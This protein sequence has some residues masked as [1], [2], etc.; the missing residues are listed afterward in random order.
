MQVDWVLAIHLCALE[1]SFN[2]PDDCWKDVWCVY[3]EEEQLWGF[4]AIY[5][6]F[7]FLFP[8]LCIHWLLSQ[9]YF[10]YVI[11]NRIARQNVF[12]ISFSTSSYSLTCFTS[13]KYLKQ[14]SQFSYP[15]LPTEIWLISYIHPF[16]LGFTAIMKIAGQFGEW[17]SFWLISLL[18]FPW[19][20]F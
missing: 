13:F 8:V 11:K 4:L 3:M 1:L 6:C 10:F 19:W 12:D 5:T 9:S 16:P 2:T 7:V 14:R 17:W 20:S 15:V 18:Y